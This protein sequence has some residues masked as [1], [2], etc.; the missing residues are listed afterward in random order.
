[1]ASLDVRERID[2]VCTVLL[3]FIGQILEI[4]AFMTGFEWVAVL[5]AV[6]TLPITAVQVW[7]KWNRINEMADTNHQD[8]NLIT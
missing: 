2:L 6:V 5:L 7:F 1:M 4:I 8:R 3:A